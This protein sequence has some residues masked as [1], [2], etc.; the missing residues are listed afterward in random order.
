MASRTASKSLFVI[1]LPN[2]KRSGTKVRIA[3]QCRH[4]Q[5]YQ[6]H[7]SLILFFFSAS[8]VCY[9]NTLDP[10]YINLPKLSHVTKHLIAASGFQ[11]QTLFIQ[12]IGISLS[13]SGFINY[14]FSLFK[15]ISYISF[16]IICH[17]LYYYITS[18]ILYISIRLLV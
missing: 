16:G 8:T 5:L 4:L 17:L 1:R 10:L 11:Y 15:T 9:L 2:L 12:T 14:F 3:Q 7:L 13:I 6:R 18:Y